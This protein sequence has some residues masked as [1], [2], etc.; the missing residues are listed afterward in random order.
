MNC[1]FLKDTGCWSDRIRS[2]EQR[3]IC[4]L[5]CSQKSPCRSL[6]TCNVPVKSFRLLSRLDVIC[7]RNCLDVCCI[8]VTVL[9]H[10]LVRLDKLW[11]LLSE[12]L[13][14]ILEDVLH[15]TVVDVAGHTQGEHVLTLVYGLSVQSAVLQTLMCQRSDRSHDDRAVLDVKFPDRIVAQSGSLESIFIK[16]IR[17]HEH[18]GSSLEPLRIGLESRRVH[19]DKKVAEVSRCGY[20]LASDMYLEARY[21]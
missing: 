14:K 5:R 20:M 2:T 17:I 3:Q 16:C 10:L 7:I 9:Q 19:C 1:Q 12:L 13:L 8:V 4:L 18:H 6:V 15:R 21:S 11:F